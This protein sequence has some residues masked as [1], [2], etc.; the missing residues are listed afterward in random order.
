M[1]LTEYLF[2][3]HDILMSLAPHIGFMEN[4]E[5]FRHRFKLDGSLSG[6]GDCEPMRCSLGG[7]G[8]LGPAGPTHGPPPVLNGA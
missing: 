2:V 5:T 4:E 3:E 6:R 7:V 1:V 8:K